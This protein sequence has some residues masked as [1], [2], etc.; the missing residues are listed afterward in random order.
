M[1]VTRIPA[2]WPG[3]DPSAIALAARVVMLSAASRTCTIGYCTDEQRVLLADIHRVTE[4]KHVAGDSFPDFL[5]GAKQRLAAHMRLE[6]P[7]PGST[8]RSRMS[9]AANR[10]T[11]SASSTTGS[12]SWPRASTKRTWVSRGC[13]AR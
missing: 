9:P 4:L 1:R 2:D 3:D 7:G 12:S 6:R 5:A 11:S 10:S 13:R 8:R